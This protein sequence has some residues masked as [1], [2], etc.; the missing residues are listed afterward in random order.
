MSELKDGYQLIFL[1]LPSRLG[2]ALTLPN[3]TPGL[4]ASL[5]PYQSQRYP[6]TSD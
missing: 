4:R 6:G 2:T 5:L 1:R 3:D